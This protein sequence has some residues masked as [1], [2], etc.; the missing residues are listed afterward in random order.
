MMGNVQKTDKLDAAG[1]ATLEHMGS[2]PTVW[3][4]AG[5]IRDERE[6]PRPQMAFAKLRT[7]IKNRIHS[8]LVKCA[9][10]LEAASDLFAPK[11]RDQLL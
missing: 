10:S 7:G 3:I 5:E 6:L 8:T 4:A 9:L 2:L 1:L 11:W